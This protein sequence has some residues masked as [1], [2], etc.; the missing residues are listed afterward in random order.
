MR[1]AILDANA[2]GG[3]KTSAF[4]VEGT[5][6]LASTLPIMTSSAGLT[7]D[8][9]GNDIIS[10]NDAVTSVMEVGRALC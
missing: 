8:G 4:A 3:T 7:I 10:G 9:A 6:T 5:I 2:D 1:Q